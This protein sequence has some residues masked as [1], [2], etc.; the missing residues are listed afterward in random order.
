MDGELKKPEWKYKNKQYMIELQRFLDKVDNVED[1]KLRLDI[2][3]QMHR[4]DNVLTQ[5]CENIVEKYK[6]IEP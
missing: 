3:Y 1:E 4:C 5:L 2:I 6:K